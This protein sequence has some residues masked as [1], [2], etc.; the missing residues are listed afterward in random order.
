MKANQ[1]SLAYMLEQSR[2]KLST[3]F[4][5]TQR[6]LLIVFNCIYLLLG[7]LYLVAERLTTGHF[8][9]HPLL[10]YV[11]LSV[12]L[13]NGVSAVYNFCVLRGIESFYLANWPIHLRQSAQQDNLFKYISI[14]SILIMS[15][16][17]MTGFGNPSNDSIMT[18][19]AFG[20]SMIVVTAVLLSRKAA[21]VWFVIMLLVLVYVVHRTGYSYQYHYLTPTESATY[22]RALAGRRPWA[23]ARQEVLRAAGLKPPQVSRYANTWI[24]YIFVAF[25]TAYYYSGLAND[26]FEVIPA[27][28]ED[29]KNVIQTS[30]QQERAR[31]LAQK[32]ADE[33]HLLQQQET[34]RAELNFLRSQLNPHFLFNTLNYLY[35]KAYD[36]SEELA[37]VIHKLAD[38]MRY[39]LRDTVDRVSLKEEIDHLGEFIELHQMRN[40][41]ELFINVTVDG[42]TEQKQ[43][44][45]FMLIELI[46]NAFKHGKMNQADSPLTIHIAASPERI[47]FYAHNRKNLKKDIKSNH[48]GLANLQRRLELTYPQKF[49]FKVTEDA[50]YYSSTLVIFS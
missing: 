23:F 25:F 21:V 36:T 43:I 47:T 12:A 50:D 7:P 20:H 15:I 39:N 13:T 45:P 2:Q 22:E 27:V 17:N 16:F 35:I 48:I 42:P 38:I 37:T 6:T 11:Y 31:E 10:A 44:P 18:D 3:P 9:P 1:E 14:G 24:I 29:I 4:A 41:Y 40:N 28:A 5:K 49:T 30:N 26:M 8:V 34:L 46:E 32:E 19:F 33:R